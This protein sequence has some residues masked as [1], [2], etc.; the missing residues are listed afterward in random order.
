ML[1]TRTA[2]RAGFAPS[3]S[4]PSRSANPRAESCAAPTEA[5]GIWRLSRVLGA[6]RWTRVYQARPQSLAADGPADYALKLLRPEYADYPLA[7]AMLRREAHVARQISHPHLSSVLS[8]VLSEQHGERE[9]F[10]VMPFLEGAT[11][12]QILARSSPQRALPEATA[13]WVGRQ[14][15]AA[16]SS[17]HGKQWLHGDIK[18]ANILVAPLGHA[19]LLDLGLARR[20][21][22][23]E[24]A[25][26]A[27]LQGSLRYLAPEALA[28]GE[29][30]TAASDIYSLGCV[31]FESLTGRPPFDC[32][33]PDDLAAAH[34]REE[35]PALRSLVP[36]MSHELARLVKQML[37]KTPLRRP[38]AEE[39]VERLVELEIATMG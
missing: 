27:S 26:G 13:L 17:L 9:R 14:I 22:S 15:A 35:A 2:P 32:E 6:G 1:S 25:N 38:A 37:A 36:Q 8:S 16:V 3:P 10:L 34:L 30:L 12:G 21:G 23:A 39:V 11:L 31:L 29:S 24:C 19:T 7:I 18:P 5:L 33:R 20:L 28:P 4:A